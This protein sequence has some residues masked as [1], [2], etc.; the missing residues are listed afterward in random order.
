MT[1]T[2]RLRFK[3]LRGREGAVGGSWVSFYGSEV[4]FLIDEVSRPDAPVYR[5]RVLPVVNG[6]GV[7]YHE[8]LHGR[9]EDARHACARWIVQNRKPHRARRSA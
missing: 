5:L 6:H 2:I 4:R 9:L 7:V 1:I 3:Q 8:S